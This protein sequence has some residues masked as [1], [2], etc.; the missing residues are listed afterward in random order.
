MKIRVSNAEC[1]E[2]E[3][4][5]KLRQA[6][7]RGNELGMACECDGPGLVSTIVYADSLDDSEHQVYQ[8][9]RSMAVMVSKMDDFE[10][11]MKAVRE[12]VDSFCAAHGM[13]MSVK[14]KSR[15]QC[16]SGADLVQLPYR[17]KGRCVQEEI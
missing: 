13:W 16:G 4:R 5:S 2:G 9:A 14:Y 6:V 1:V 17:E 7:G 11:T 12:R 15:S 8:E 10:C 3:V